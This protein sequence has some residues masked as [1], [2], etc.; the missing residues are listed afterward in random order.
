M[1]EVNDDAKVDAKGGFR[2]IELLTGPGRRRR[3]SAEEKARIVA[4]TLDNFGTVNGISGTT[5]AGGIY[6][7]AL[8]SAVTSGVVVNETNGFIGGDLYG[9]FVNGPASITNKA[10]GTISANNAAASYLRYTSTVINYGLIQDSLNTGVFLAGGGTVINKIGGTITGSLVGVRIFGVGTVNNAGT[11]TG[12]STDAVF[13]SNN[14]S[15][16]LVIVNPGAVFNGRIS[17]G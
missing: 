15:S 3:W 2:R 12:T 17:G 4:E 7:G 16:N 14:Y 13:F 11:I 5:G 1:F 9:V 10:G 8:G 6:L